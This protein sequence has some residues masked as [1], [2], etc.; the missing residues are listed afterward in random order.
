MSD[1]S[2]VLFTTHHVDA[3]RA[4]LHGIWDTASPH[5][6]IVMVNGCDEQIAGYLMRQC[7]RGQISS[8]AFDMG[9]GPAGHCGLDRGFHFAGGKYL[10]RARDG[11][12]FEPGWLEQ[13]IDALE[14]APEVGCLGLVESGGRR[15]RGR[16]PKPHHRPVLVD[17]VDTAC[18]ITPHHVFERHESELLGE[19][20]ADHCAYQARL[21]EIGM[22]L[23]FCPGLVKRAD[24]QTA[25]AESRGGIDTLLP[26][27]DQSNGAQE[28]IRQVYQLGE[29]VLLTCMSCGNNELEVLAAVVE[30]CPTHGS[31]IGYTYTLRCGSCQELQYEEDM[32]LRCPG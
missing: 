5:E 19:R 32:Q 4:A 13:A 17:A 7:R 26:L 6:I 31:P 25:V 20:P 12:V 9:G 18:F 22:Q 29:D 30:F 16:P 3:V 11:L 21:R 2:V 14:A 10:V 8:F 27:H 1:A 24:A 23:A 15:R 28:P